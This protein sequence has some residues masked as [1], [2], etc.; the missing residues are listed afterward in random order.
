MDAHRHQNHFEDTVKGKRRGVEKKQG[1]GKEKRSRTRPT[2]SLLQKIEKRNWL[3]MQSLWIVI[4]SLYSENCYS[5]PSNHPHMEVS[6]WILW[7][8]LYY[9]TF[10]HSQKNS[11]GLGI[12]CCY[13]ETNVFLMSLK[14]L[15]LFYFL[16]CCFSF[17]EAVHLF[18]SFYHCQILSFIHIL[19]NQINC[20]QLAWNTLYAV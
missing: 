5:I 13:H 16:C 12:L 2:F 18:P 7:L 20:I 9:P 8:F 19:K 3:L 10:Q 17:L 15:V 11:W 4:T 14:T 6:C 1:E